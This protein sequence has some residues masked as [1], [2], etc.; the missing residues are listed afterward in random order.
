[1]VAA[2]LPTAWSQ[3][4]VNGRAQIWTPYLYIDIDS[5]IAIKDEI[6]KIFANKMLYPT[7]R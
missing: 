5:A 4:R 1:M 7:G 6:E 2:L 3:K